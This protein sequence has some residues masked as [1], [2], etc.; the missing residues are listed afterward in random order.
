MD[1]CQGSEATYKYKQIEEVTNRPIQ[2]Y[3]WRDQE[4]KNKYKIDIIVTKYNQV[5]IYEIMHNHRVIIELV[6]QVLSEIT[7][8]KTDQSIFKN[9]KLIKRIL[10]IYSCTKYLNPNNI[11]LLA[12]S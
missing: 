10:K 2:K 3:W 5:K 8:C 6:T 9:I 7:Y 11:N 4:P 1:I 12:Y